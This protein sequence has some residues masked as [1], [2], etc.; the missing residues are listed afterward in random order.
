[1][2][3]QGPIV[4]VA[5]DV[6]TLDQALRIAETA[7]KAGADWLE[8]GTPLIVFE[9]V[10]AIGALA[11]TFPEVPILA[12]YKMMDGVAKYVHEAARQGGQLVTICGVAS[13]A[14]IRAAVKAGREQGIK[15]VA[16]LYAVK[17][18]PTRAQELAM[19]GVDSVYVH[20]GA[21]QRAEDP[22]QDPLAGLQEVCAAAGI[23]VGVGTFS[24]EDGM[25]AFR[26]GA[27]IATIG[28]P[29]IA[30][31]NPGV[32]LREY[33]NKGKEAYYLSRAN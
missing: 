13:D 32:A 22:R 3:I 7:V 26:V 31:D 8:A 23:P 33:V 30:S 9:G 14:S 1:M 18:L 4:Q 28:F 16:D 24:V 29:L 20:L 19:L 27:T 5:I 12:D 25:E 10:E 21:D 17:D 6:T 2:N 15:V 11:R